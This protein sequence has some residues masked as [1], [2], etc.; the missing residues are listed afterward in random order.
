MARE[1][2][3]KI[4]KEPEETPEKQK[5]RNAHAGNARGCFLLNRYRPESE[6][7]GE[8]SHI[9]WYSKRPQG[10]TN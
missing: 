2:L 3:K 10:V 9:K 1:K 8:V 7:E 5:L 4:S 6:R